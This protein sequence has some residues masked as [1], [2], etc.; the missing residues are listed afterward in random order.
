MIDMA[1]EYDGAGFEVSKQTLFLHMARHKAKGAHST[2]GHLRNKVNE[3][4]SRHV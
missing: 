2:R 4:F 3:R 1:Q